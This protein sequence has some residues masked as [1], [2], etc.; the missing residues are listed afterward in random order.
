MIEVSVGRQTPVLQYFPPS[1]IPT[2]GSSN[3]CFHLTVELSVF[4][5]TF[6]AEGSVELLHVP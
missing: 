2:F 3:Q 6:G 4:M 5:V 1:N